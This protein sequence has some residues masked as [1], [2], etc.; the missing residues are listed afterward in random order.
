MEF[1]AN[2][3]SK[4]KLLVLSLVIKLEL[5][6][7]NDLKLRSEFYQVFRHIDEEQIKDELDKYEEMLLNTNSIIQ[8]YN[9]KSHKNKHKGNSKITKTPTS[10]IRHKG[11]N[12]VERKITNGPQNND[13]IRI[14]N[15]NAKM[16]SPEKNK[17]NNN[18]EYSAGK[19]KFIKRRRKPMFKTEELSE[20]LE[21]ITIADPS[22]SKKVNQKNLA[23]TLASLRKQKNQDSLNYNL[24]GQIKPAFKLKYDW[25]PDFSITSNN[26]SKTTKESNIKHL[27]GEEL[28]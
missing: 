26:K 1:S 11:K 19:V 24:R 15:P 13:S 5:R 10:K 8:E 17:I 9:E 20:F 14:P 12:S 25:L 23:E 21:S 4:V 16:M 2:I 7:E 18:K 6:K 3:I 22:K 28:V 27:T